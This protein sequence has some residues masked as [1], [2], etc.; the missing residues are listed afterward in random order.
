MATPSAVRNRDKS[1]AIAKIS[2][3][4][5]NCGGGTNDEAAA[6]SLLAL[7]WVLALPA[8]EL[9][10]FQALTNGGRR[11]SS[12]CIISRSRSWTSSNELG[13]GC[14]A[15]EGEGTAAATAEEEAAPPLGRKGEGRGHT[16]ELM[17]RE[18]MWRLL[19]LTWEETAALGAK[20]SAPAPLRSLCVAIGSDPFDARSSCAIVAAK[21]A[22]IAAA[23][24]AVGGASV[25][26]AATSVAGTAAETT[27]AGGGG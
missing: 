24:G 3:N 27:G 2:G 11:S 13:G 15:E 7:R 10:A 6:A 18:T 19:A 5:I 4:R 20:N 21:A 22:L 17:R 14:D 25:G 12:A 23:E 9:L 8:A 1:A 16:Y 26:G